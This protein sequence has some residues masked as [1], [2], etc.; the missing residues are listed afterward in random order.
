MGGYDKI[1][2]TSGGENV[3]FVRKVDDLGGGLQQADT[4]YISPDVFAKNYGARTKLGRQLDE[5]F[6][7]ESAFPQD[8]TESPV[9][10]QFVRKEF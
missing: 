7:R 9:F 6:V 4:R 10:S 8:E 1:V 2:V 3:D 5:E